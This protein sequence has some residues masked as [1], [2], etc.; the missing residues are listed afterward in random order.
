MME[1][2]VVV[3]PRAICSPR[4]ITSLWHVMRDRRRRSR[5]GPG[6]Q[7][8]YGRGLG[9]SSTLISMVTNLPGSEMYPFHPDGRVYF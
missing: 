6:D 7:S 3:D 9:Y 4:A 8:T 5:G 1:E 2:E